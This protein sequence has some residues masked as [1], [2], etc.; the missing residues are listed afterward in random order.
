MDQT[1]V[2]SGYD[3]EIALAGRY[4]QYLLLLA[5]DI[6][7]L[8]DEI[9]FGA[10]PIRVQL[11]Q[12]ADVDRT[13]DLSAGAPVPDLATRDG[14]FTVEVLHGDPLGA[15]LRIDLRLRLTRLSDGL[16][17]PDV[18]LQ[19]FVKLHIDTTSRSDG[20]G[21]ESVSMTTELT[22]VAGDLVGI[23]RDQGHDKA[24][25]I[26]VMKPSLGQTFSLDRLGSGGRL[27]DVALRK[28]AADPISGAP[29]VLV[30]YLNLV[31]KAG[32]QP[33][34]YIGPRG[35]A[36]LGQNFLEPD[37]DITFATRHG[38]LADV[39]DDAM[40]RRAVP[41]GAGYDFPLVA[42]SG[43][44]AERVGRYV[45]IDAGPVRNINGATENQLHIGVEAEYEI[46]NFFDPNFKIHIVMTQ[47]V[48][49]EGIISWETDLDV[50]AGL[51]AHIVISL[52]SVAM[53][54][55]L[56]PWALL[57]FTGLEI[58]LHTVEEL[59]AAVK[60]NKVEAKV[61]ATLL[62]VAPNRFTIVRRR[63]DPL[64][65]TQ[66][67]IGL[68]PGGMLITDD[69]LAIWG[70]AALTRATKPVPR[71]VIREAVRASDDRAVELRYLVG[72]PGEFLDDIEAAT[73]RLPFSQHDPAREPLLFTVPVE[74]T[75]AGPGALERA[76]HQQI[77][78]RHPYI[79]KAI[80]VDENQ[81]EH[82]LVISEQ[83]SNDVQ[84]VLLTAHTEQATA[85]ITA[86]HEAEVRAAVE[87]HFADLGIIPAPEQ[88]EIA[89][90]AQLKALIAADLE[91]YK[92][93]QLPIDLD[94]QLR[95]QLRLELS[96]TEFGRLQDGGLLRLADFD[97]IHFRGSERSYY[98]D[99]YVASIETT[100][101]LRE[102]DNLRHKPRYRNTATGRE[103]LSPGR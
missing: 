76:E 73:L 88:V 25:L 92:E 42:G 24:E 39:G 14:A 93:G 58:G 26:E 87:Q 91:A 63:W 49:D 89:V 54:P 64:F 22:D 103:F 82:L 78:G 74:S 94:A 62:D 51:L 72:N 34:N 95:Q 61:D 81:I 7:L 68:R 59:V 9:I 97:L 98:R 67:Q 19:V 83:E 77:R 33:D 41:A 53:V 27:F 3:V 50:Q 86:D 18:S 90:A 55:L 45:S 16:S 6:G 65:E 30:V 1:K 46:D 4:L 17:L 44:D 28:L 32:P 56:G 15:D 48:D 37:A 70:K 20:P 10:D 5:S 85:Q 11:Q 80:E 101:A 12:P 35:D 40:Y 47:S 84:G 102:A 8:P 60:E 38:L 31:L 2:L 43:S 69:G 79:V 96:P 57:V 52:V 75:A 71:V 100:P 23:A 21:L 66:H 99:R 13:Y 36:A 29:A